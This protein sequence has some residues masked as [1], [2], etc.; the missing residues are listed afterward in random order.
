M[1]WHCSKV[2]CCPLLGSNTQ[3]SFSLVPTCCSR[4]GLAMKLTRQ[5]LIHR[6]VQLLTKGTLLTWKALLASRK[7]TFGSHT[8]TS[9]ERSMYRCWKHLS[10]VFLLVIQK[11]L[12]IR[13]HWNSWLDMGSDNLVHHLLV[14]LLTAKGH[15]PCIVKSMPGSKFSI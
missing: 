10:K 5:E 3:L 13:R 12:S 7:P 2:M 11:L 15:N 4:A 1:R 6:H 8:L 14:F 9:P